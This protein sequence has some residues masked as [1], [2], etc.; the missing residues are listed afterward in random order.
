MVLTLVKSESPVLLVASPAPDGVDPL[1][2]QLGHGSG[3]GQLELP[4]LADRDLLAA[5][6]AAFMPM[7]TRNTHDEAELSE[8]E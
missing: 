6:G 2:S 8:K 1:R 3:A 5:G 4:L 7:I